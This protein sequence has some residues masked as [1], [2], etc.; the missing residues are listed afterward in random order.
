MLSS[1]F[2]SQAQ[3]VALLVMLVLFSPLAIDI[4]LPALPM[5]AGEFSVPVASVQDTI[6]WFLASLGLGQLIAGPFADRFGRRPVALTGI[7][8]YCLSAGLAWYASNLDMLLLARIFQGFGACATSV[9]AFAAVRDQ[10]SGKKAGQMISYLNGAICFIP[11]LAPLLGSWLTA[12]FGWR[13]NFSFMMGYGIFAGLIMAFCLPETKPQSTQV[14]GRLFSVARYSVVLKEPIF[15]FHASICALAM[16]IILAYVTSAPIWLIERMGLTMQEFTFWFGVNAFFNIVASMTA[17]KF[18]DRFGTRKTL[19]IG[20]M[21][22][23]FAGTLMLAFSTI[24]SPWAFMTPIIFSSIG[25]A[26]VL[27]SAAGKA[28]EP[29]GQRA[30]TAAALLGLFQMSGAGV[31]V[32]LTQRLE[33]SEPQLLAFHLIIVAPCLLLLWS[34]TGQRLHAAD[35]HA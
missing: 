30:G 20:L 23:V 9:A 21:V 3:R 19:K 26:W 7:A 5:M 33:F 27:G 6:S 28:L 29:F 8:L 17:P 4:Y 1:L 35:N 15:L 10:F 24:F 25:F 22:L 16:A 11:A 14:Q 32:S 13:S 18:M 31:L 12:E 34:K 2:S